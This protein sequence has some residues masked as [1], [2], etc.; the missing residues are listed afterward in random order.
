M[1]ISVVVTCTAAVICF[2]AA[3]E[4][5]NSIAQD[6]Q[7]A[8]STNENFWSSQGSRI[9]N[10]HEKLFPQSRKRAAL[11]VTLIAAFGLLFAT[12]FLVR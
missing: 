3:L 7:E 11:A 12:A 5:G 9:W 1:R 2:V 4:F 10:E 6:V 8:L